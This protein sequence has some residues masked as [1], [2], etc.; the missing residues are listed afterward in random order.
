[1][2]TTQITVGTKWTTS[3]GRT[4]EVTEIKP[5]GK[6]EVRSGWR[7]G[8]MRFCDIRAAMNAGGAA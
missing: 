7:F 6:A 1:M 2:T 5:F 3:D 4:W 8:Q